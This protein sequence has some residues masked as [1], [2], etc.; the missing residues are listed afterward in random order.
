M[1]LSVFTVS[2]PDLTPRELGAAA[3]AAGIEGIEWRFK[4]IPD[5]ALEES[6]SFWRHNRCSI[7]PGRWEEETS[8]CIDVASTYHLKSIALVPYLNDLDLQATEQA[9]QAASRLG[10]SLVRV[11]VPSYD[12]TT[13][14]GDLYSSATRYLSQVQEYAQQYHVKAMIETHHVTIAPSAS[15][16]HRL[17]ESFDPTHIGVLYD[18]GNMVHEG[19]ENYRM[20]LEL[21]GPYLAHV[22]IKNA[23]WTPKKQSDLIRPGEANWEGVWTQID[24]GIVPWLE[25][26]RDLHSVGYEGYVGIEDFSGTYDSIEML[27]QAANLFRDLKDQL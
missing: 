16:A 3:S 1:K 9:F 12:R 5:D 14:Y 27:E 2:V 21:L 6:P 4:G 19:F 7:N 26:M 24:K 15:L 17:V 8:E 23:V 20:G 25:V 18:P 10:A 22:H 13:S 11:G